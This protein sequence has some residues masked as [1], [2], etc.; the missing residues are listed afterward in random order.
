M[1]VQRLKTASARAKDG[2]K[3]EDAA[4]IEDDH[5]DQQRL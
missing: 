1:G 2:G 4:G 5:R 3:T